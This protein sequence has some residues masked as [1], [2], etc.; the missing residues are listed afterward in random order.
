MRKVSM[1]L[2]AAAFSI[3]AKA[4]IKDTLLARVEPP[5]K[6]SKA[7]DKAITIK[8]PCGGKRKEVLGPVERL[9]A[10]KPLIELLCARVVPL[11]PSPISAV[12]L[13]CRAPGVN[14]IKIQEYDEA[15]KSTLAQIEIYPNP[16]QASSFI[17]FKSPALDKI[18]KVRILN[19]SG[20]HI[21]TEKILTTMNGIQS[22]NL[23]KLLQSTYFIC[24]QTEKSREPLVGKLII[25]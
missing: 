11:F 13:Q 14:V 2:V 9:V 17:H 10:R 6:I 19:A 1:F 3:C 4:Q 25:Q 12:R 8:V 16:V 21:V 18:I 20:Q 23:P 7:D 15:P 24:I 5:L 22:M